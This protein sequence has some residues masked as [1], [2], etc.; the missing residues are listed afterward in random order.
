MALNSGMVVGFAVSWSKKRASE[1]A[2]LSNSTQATPYGLALCAMKPVEGVCEP[3]PRKYVIV[4]STEPYSYCEAWMKLYK[5]ACSQFN[6]YQGYHGTK[7]RHYL[8]HIP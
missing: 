6:E 8:H 1:I 5:I 7:S 2:E 4:P 3:K